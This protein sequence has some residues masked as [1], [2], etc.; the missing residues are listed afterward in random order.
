MPKIPIKISIII[1]VLNEEAIL[2]HISE[3]LQSIKEQGHEVIIV[4]GGS[5]D[6]TLTMAHEIAD[7]VIISKAGRALQMN[8]GAAIASGE[9]LLFLHA[10]TFLPDNTIQVILDSYQKNNYLG[11]NHPDKH[12]WG[13]FDVRLSSSKLVYRLIESLMNLRSCLTSIATGDQAIFVEKKLFNSVGQFPEIALMEDI[14]ISRQLK[15]IAKPVCIKQKVVTSSRRWENNG[16]IATV[17]LMWKLRLYYFFGVSPE[18]L[19]Q[20]Y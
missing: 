17:L 14:A 11:K 5:A 12:Y 2:S 4:D 20:L 18:K 13:R 15:K 19:N 16:V 1:P 3:H 6:N 7:T 9:I 10:D 8:N